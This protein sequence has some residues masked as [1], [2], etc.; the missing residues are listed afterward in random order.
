MQSLK[1]KQREVVEARKN[2][3]MGKL[4]GGASAAPGR[5]Q[6]EEAAARARGEPVGDPRKGRQGQGWGLIVLATLGGVM[7][8]AAAGFFAA[9]FVQGP[10]V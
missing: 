6:V 5:R 10:S 2:M 7:A 3:W 1:I 9:R 4:K 8:F